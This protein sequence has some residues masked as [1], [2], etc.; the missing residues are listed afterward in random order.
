MVGQTDHGPFQQ[1]MELCCVRI[2][3]CLGLEFLKLDDA[4][5][6]PSP[7]HRRAVTQLPCLQQSDR[8]VLVRRRIRLR[9][10]A[11]S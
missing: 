8:H 1:I 9:P 6:E 3:F 11:A 7:F 2:A 10:V 4:V 5:Q